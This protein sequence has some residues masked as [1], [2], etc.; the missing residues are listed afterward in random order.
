[1]TVIPTSATSLTE[2]IRG[3]AARHPERLAV[4]QVTDPDEP[5][6][7]RWWS[8]GRLDEQAR[9][10]AAHLQQHGSPGDRVMSLIPA[11]TT[12]SLPSW[13]ACT[14]GWWRCPRRFPAGTA[15]SCGVPRQ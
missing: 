10:L 1:M 15:T 2:V 14:P 3:H 12:S 8:Y 11:G 13:A 7:V 6:G 5:D 9:R 4:A